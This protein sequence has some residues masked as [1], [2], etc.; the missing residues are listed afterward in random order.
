MRKSL[1]TTAEWLQKEAL[2]AAGR[3]KLRTVVDDGGGSGRR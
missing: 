1:A 2:A 3:R